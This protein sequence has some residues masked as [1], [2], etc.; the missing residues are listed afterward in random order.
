MEDC[1][2]YTSVRVTERALNCAISHCATK[3]TLKTKDR[4]PNWAKLEE[5]AGYSS[6]SDK[7]AIR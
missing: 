1:R 3:D 2:R 7:D 6:D 5:G 4:L